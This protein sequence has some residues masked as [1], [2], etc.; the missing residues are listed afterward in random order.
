MDKDLIIVLLKI[1]GYAVAAI[2]GYLTTVSLCSCTA[3][4]SSES[5]G[6]TTITVVD[7]TYIE[8]RGNYNIQ[9]K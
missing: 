3:Y 7:T 9:V 1:V 6:K 4:R 2:L 5:Y 8:H